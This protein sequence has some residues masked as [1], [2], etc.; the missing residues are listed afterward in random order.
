VGKKP[1][2]TGALFLFGKI[3]ANREAMDHSRERSARPSRADRNRQR[4]I[5]ALQAQLK[6]YPPSSAEY[7]A[8]IR[9]LR[10]LT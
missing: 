1:K 4:A 2:K 8:I 5:D 10:R 3:P 9:Q 7:K 6:K